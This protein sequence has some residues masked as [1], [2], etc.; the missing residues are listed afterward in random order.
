MERDTGARY[1]HQGLEPAKYLWSI[2]IRLSD[3]SD[4]R[5]LRTL[6]QANHLSWTDMDALKSTV[7]EIISGHVE[8][9]PA[10]GIF[11]L[12]ESAADG[13]KAMDERLDRIRNGPNAERVDPSNRYNASGAAV[14]P[15]P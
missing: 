5:L 15:G 3:E 8:S 4:S 2:F 14:T 12:R 6:Q 13:I 11:Q 9:N 7:N 1:E 10:K